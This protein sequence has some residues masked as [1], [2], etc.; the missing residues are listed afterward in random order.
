MQRRRPNSKCSPHKMPPVQSPARGGRPPSP[1]FPPPLNDPSPQSIR[2]PHAHLRFLIYS[3]APAL[4][5]VPET[6]DCEYLI[7]LTKI[8][9]CKVIVVRSGAK[10]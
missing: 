5:P 9:T 3:A 1:P 10:E 4:L 8:S 7:E 2:N 6:N